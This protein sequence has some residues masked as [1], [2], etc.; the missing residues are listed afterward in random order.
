MS[1]PKRPA[2]RPSKVEERPIADVV[3]VG[4]GSVETGANDQSGAVFARYLSVGL[5]TLF[6]ERV[7][8][9]L[10]SRQRFHKARLECLSR[11]GK[12]FELRDALFQLLDTI[13]FKLRLLPPRPHDPDPKFGE[14]VLFVQVLGQL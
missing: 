14:R 3:I 13:I 11:S 12:V 9:A 6:D 7:A 8:N 5:L 4:V 2:P 10:S 1:K